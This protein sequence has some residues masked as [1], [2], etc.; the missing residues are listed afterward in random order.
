[1]TAFDRGFGPDA[2]VVLGVARK[3]YDRAAKP[4]PTK[5]VSNVPGRTATS[6]TMPGPSMSTARR[7]SVKS[8]S[9]VR[10]AK[11]AV[12]INAG[13][14]PNV[15]VDQFNAEE[16]KLQLRNTT[17]SWLALVSRGPPALPHSACRPSSRQYSAAASSLDN[18]AR[19]NVLR[20]LIALPM[21]WVHIR[22]VSAPPPTALPRFRW[23]VSKTAPRGT[24]DLDRPPS[25][26]LRLKRSGSD[27]S[28]PSW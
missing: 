7:R 3:H 26:M 4:G 12:L 2:V 9:G 28:R 5:V 21:G 14:A 20:I 25:R 1:M 6:R 24:E 10:G 18:R 23:P 15:T 8:Q 22:Q 27:A 17:R 13:T 11:L 16:A 19:M